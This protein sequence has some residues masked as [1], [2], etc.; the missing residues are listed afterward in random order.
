MLALTM[1]VACSTDDDPIVV[2][3]ISLSSH[4]A[5]FGAEGGST[6]I[7]IVPYPETMA[8]ESRAEKSEWFDIN[9]S[10]NSM[11]ITAK[12]NTSTAARRGEVVIFSPEGDFEQETIGIAQEGATAVALSHSAAEEHRFDSEGDKYVFNIASNYE[13]RVTV[14]VDWISVSED[15]DGG[16]ATLVAEANTSFAERSATA[17]ITAGEGDNTQSATISLRQGTHDDNPYFKLLGKW[18][19]TADKWLY[20]TNGSLNSMDGS[21]SASQ[22]YLIFDIEEGEYNKTLYMRNFLYPGTSLEVRYDPA[23]ESFVIPFGWSV[24]A[25]EVFLYITLVSGNQFSYAALEVPVVPSGDYTI[26][27]P[28]MPSVNGYNYVGFGL[29]AYGDNGEKE[30]FGSNMYPTMYPMSNIKFIKHTN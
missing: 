19:I 29:W 27:T 2:R 11:T 18:E 6:T 1:M 24:Y 12:A 26:L 22:Y 21:P 8:W 25:Y 13:W 20:T 10:G 3:S 9:I 4:A 28:K 16:R 14:D 7:D 23:T 30:A 15:Y 17:T 5:V